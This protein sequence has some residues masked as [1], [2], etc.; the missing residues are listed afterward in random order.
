[1]DFGA[2]ADGKDETDRI[3]RCKGADEPTLEGK[4]EIDNWLWFFQLVEVGQILSDDGQAP[5]GVAWDQR[6][7]KIGKMI[8]E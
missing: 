5:R 1:L 8:V 3:G 4:K 6:L 2:R 7:K